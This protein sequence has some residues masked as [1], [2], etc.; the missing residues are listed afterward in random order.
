MFDQ[1]TD[2]I[3]R[4]V[5]DIGRMVDEF[6]GFARMPKPTKEKA[7]LRNILKDAIFLREMGNTHVTFIRDLGE[8]PLDGTFDSRMLG[9]AFGNIIKNAVEAIEAL[10][11]DAV[12]GDLKVM[13]RSRLNETSGQFV[14]DIIDNGRRAA[15]RK[16]SSHSRALYDDARK[17][18]RRLVSRSSRRSSR[19]MAGNWN[20]M[21]HPPISIAA[22]AL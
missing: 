15:D 6:S 18:H 3:V 9:Q 10:P 8:E 22:K 4:Q 1:C 2:T 14:V 7:D 13:V 20:C 17:G 16:S 5:E 12:R 19:T 21:T 11:A